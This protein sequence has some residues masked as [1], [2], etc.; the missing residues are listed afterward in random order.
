MRLGNN[1]LLQIV[2]ISFLVFLLSSSVRSDDMTIKQ[3]IR[4]AFSLSDQAKGSLGYYYGA[5]GTFLNTNGESIR[6]IKL[7]LNQFIESVTVNHSSDGNQVFVDYIF[8]STAAA[9]LT[10][11]GFRII[12]T[13]EDIGLVFTCTSDDKI[14]LESLPVICFSREPTP[15]ENLDEYE[16]IRTELEEESPE[17]A[18]LKPS[19]EA[20]ILSH[21]GRAELSKLFD[22]KGSFHEAEH[23]MIDMPGGNYNEPGVITF[24]EDYRKAVIEYRFGRG[25]LER[26]NGKYVQIIGDGSSGEL[27]W[28][29]RSNDHIVVEH[30]PDC[31]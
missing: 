30:N 8:G 17:I 20:F 11:K 6:E 22:D 28:S 24:S 5:N 12:G 14:V 3:Q 21:E 15:E 9:E 26:S 2:L 19:V 31:D 25:A 23:L 10:G 4:E 16:L 29:C 1:G 13:V 7:E 27:K 18:A